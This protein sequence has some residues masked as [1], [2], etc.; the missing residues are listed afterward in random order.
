MRRS[1]FRF[2]TVV[3]LF[4]SL[5]L[6]ACS[7]GGGGNSGGSGGG[8]SQAAEA[9]NQTLYFFDGTSVITKIITT[10]VDGSQKISYSQG[11]PFGNP[12]IDPNDHVTVTGTYSFGG[13]S[14]MLRGIVEPKITTAPQ[15]TEAK[16]PTNWPSS[17]T[18]EAPHVSQA[19]GT[20][21][22]NTTYMA[23]GTSDATAFRQATLTPDGPAAIGAIRDPNAFVKA[24]TTGTYNLHW[25]TPDPAGPGYAANF[26]Q[27]NSSYTLPSSTS[28]FGLTLSA[29]TTAC[30]VA[31]ANVANCGATLSA[32]S[33]EVVAAWNKGWTGKGQNVL[34]IDGLATP[35][36]TDVKYQHP[37]MVETV[38]HRYAWGATF[39]GMS[40]Q[41]YQSFSS[42]STTIPSGKVINLSGDLVPIS[43]PVK[44]H[45]INMSYGANLA[46]A[47][48]R[49]NLVTNPWTVSELENQRNN[50]SIYQNEAVYLASSSYDGAFNFSDAVLTKSAGN[51]H[52]DAQYEPFSWYLAQNGNDVTR[53]LI[54]GALTGIGTTT[55]KVDIADYSNRAGGNALI[56]SRFLLESGLSAY[57]P[58]DNAY[59]G[60]ELAVKPGT[61]FAAPRV[62]AY[63]AIVRQK[64]PNLTAPNTADILLA[65]ARYDT[66]TCY[67]NCDKAIYGQGE[68]SLSRALAPV[69]YLR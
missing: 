53:L 52:I 65:T 18:V 54:V 42:P 50:L 8:A 6:A 60:Y 59:G 22:D 57:R 27:G 31:G 10:L 30:K 62:S 64:F 7:G 29:N 11:S 20:Y 28:I 4:S 9:S 67:P 48:G 41:S 56:Q 25:G 40:Y 19:S 33:D 55:G 47:I 46:N 26:N 44:L 32:P 5:A 24:P 43:Q 12:T 16:Y 35:S 66:L 15:L 2:N 37:A 21:I 69:G 58:G 49:E 45:V 14:Q 63:A 36:A 34:I 23:D 1:I 3:I 61:S 51:D 17:G 13:Q 39:Y 68:A 38:A